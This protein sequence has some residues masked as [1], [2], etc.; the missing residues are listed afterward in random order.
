MVHLIS[1]AIVISLLAINGVKGVLYMNCMDCAKSNSGYNFMCAYDGH[2]PTTDVY[3]QAC[4]YPG[5]PSPF[6]QPS[7]TNICSAS[8]LHDG[9][10]F[11]TKC[12]LVNA[13][14]CGLYG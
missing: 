3:N 1:M 2:L 12:P 7:D 8:R 13:T 6:C 4:C 11:Y 10:H 5:D 9:H 14:G